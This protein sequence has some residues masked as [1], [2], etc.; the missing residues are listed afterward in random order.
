MF[1]F[2]LPRLLLGLVA[3]ASI[4]LAVPIFQSNFDQGTL[5]TPGGSSLFLTY[6][7]SSTLSN[8]WNVGNEIDH[9]GDYWQA[10]PGGGPYSV[11]LAGG[12]S[13]SIS[14]QISGLS[15]G[16]MYYVS[17]WLAGNPDW[18]EPWASST[19][20]NPLKTVG[21]DVGA[22]SGQFTFDSTGATRTDM[23]WVFRTFSFT[24]EGTNMSLSFSDVNGA[25]GFGAV[26]AGVS[27]QA[28]PEPATMALLGGALLGLA[29][30]R[31]RTAR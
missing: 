2:A 6:P 27:V 18:Q 5:P 26:I 30:L 25:G 9:I 14:T 17:F 15:T 28:V 20:N 4:S 1:K 8:V 16:G 10:S 12:S 11:D 21:V 19:P 3:S 13:G 29:F 7:N 24:A 23:G 22:Q 31:R